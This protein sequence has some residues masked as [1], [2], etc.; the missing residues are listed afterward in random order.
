MSKRYRK[1]LRQIWI[2]GHFK[3][4]SQEYLMFPLKQGFL[5]AFVYSFSFQKAPKSPNV[6]IIL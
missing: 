5:P 2:Q 1:L 4:I 3:K 6:R